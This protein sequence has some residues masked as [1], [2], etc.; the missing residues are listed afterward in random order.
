MID[1]EEQ[2][3]RD[4]ARHLHELLG[5]VGLRAQA[6]AVGFLALIE[7][8]L[9]AGVLDDAAIDRIKD[10]VYTDIT[11][12]RTAPTGR[13]EFEATLKKRLDILFPKHDHEAG[14]ERPTVGHEDHAPAE[15]KQ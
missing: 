12:S 11:V 6:T 13:D 7:E 3:R 9:K 5:F 8:L 14:S 15:L 4:E 2:K 10:Q 1:K